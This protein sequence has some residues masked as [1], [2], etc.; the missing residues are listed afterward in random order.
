MPSPVAVRF[1]VTPRADS[2]FTSRPLLNSASTLRL[3]TQQLQTLHLSSSTAIQIYP[4][5]FRIHCSTLQILRINSK[6]Q[7]YVSHPTRKVNDML[8]TCL[9]LNRSNV[10]SSSSLSSESCMLF[11]ITIHLRINRHCQSRPTRI[12]SRSRSRNKM[13]IAFYAHDLTIL[14]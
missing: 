6:C 1:L 11:V 10:P 13:L 14:T 12:P 3:R 8:G 5:S 4:G 7:M 2:S 9:L